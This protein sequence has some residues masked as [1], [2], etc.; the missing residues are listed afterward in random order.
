M[1]GSKTLI[2]L[3]INGGAGNQTQLVSGMLEAEPSLTAALRSNTA[4]SSIDLKATGIFSDATAAEALIRSLTAHPTM[5][6]LCLSKNPVAGADRTRIGASLGALVAANAPPLTR[7]DLSGCNL[8]DE[9]LGPLVDALKVNTNLGVLICSGNTMS[10]MF[11]L[12]RRLPA[13]LANTGLHTLE[14]VSF[15]DAG[16]ATQS[17]RVL[18]ELVD[19]RFTARIARHL[20][21]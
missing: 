6:D 21:D 1:L 2:R 4:L 7:L 16:G 20:A 5:S 10:E 13:V 3:D 12:K 8:C 17:L 14:L 9:C 18:E 19:L 15:G 11:V